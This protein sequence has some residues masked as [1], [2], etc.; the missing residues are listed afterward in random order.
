MKRQQYSDTMEGFIRE[1]EEQY[2][3]IKSDVP[4]NLTKR[5]RIGLTTLCKRIADDDDCDDD[6][7][8]C[9]LDR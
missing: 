2:S 3:Q 1:Q 6:D 9:V 4:I 8:D 7:D 5:E